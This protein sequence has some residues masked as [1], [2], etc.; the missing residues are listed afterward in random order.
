MAADT[1]RIFA[2]EGATHD[3]VSI[4]GASHARIAPAAFAKRDKVLRKSVVTK[5][6]VDVEVY[7][8]NPRALLALIAATKANLVISVIR[9]DGSTGTETL[10]DVYFY[11]EIDGVDI[12]EA[13][14]G[15]KLAGMGIRGRCIGTAAITTKRVSA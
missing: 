8:N 11:Q 13:D 9:D 4:D 3:A 2:H 5:T 14:E 12:P 1:G 6:R 15:G 7:G 10:V